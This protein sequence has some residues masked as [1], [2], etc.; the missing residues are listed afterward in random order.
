ME[1]FTHNSSN[2]TIKHQQQDNS[3]TNNSNNRKSISDPLQSPSCSTTSV[4]SLTTSPLQPQQHYSQDTNYIGITINDDVPKYNNNVSRHQ[5]LN[6]YTF[7]NNNNNTKH[8]RH[9]SIP[10]SLNLHELPPPQKQQQGYSPIYSH[11]QP[12]PSPRSL[13]NN[14]SYPPSLSPIGV[15]NQVI[16]EEEQEDNNLYMIQ[17]ELSGAF[18]KIRTQADL[19]MS[20]HR[21]AREGKRYGV[22]A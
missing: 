1:S 20:H 13:S 15:R 3:N 9:A 6:E 12:L 7:K 8:V 4:S 5:S 19:P 18:R 16:L 2:N 11:Q 22:S 14:S 17:T 10:H 21:R